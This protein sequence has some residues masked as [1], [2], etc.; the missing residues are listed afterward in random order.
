MDPTIPKPAS[1]YKLEST[2]VYAFYC[3]VLS[4]SFNQQPVTSLRV[5]R[6]VLG[7]LVKKK[8]LQQWNMWL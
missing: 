6:T 8:M 4:L 3:P 5:V 2:N 1:V 7:R